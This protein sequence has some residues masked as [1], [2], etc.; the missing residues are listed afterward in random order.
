MYGIDYKTIDIEAASDAF[1]AELERGLEGKPSSLKM[2][3]AYVS[4]PEKLPEEGS[5]LAIDAG[6]TH[7]RLAEVF[8]EKEGMRVGEVQDMMMPGFREEISS[9]E[10]FERMAKLISAYGCEEV[11][12]CFSYPGRVLPDHDAEIVE[13][14]KEIFI[15][16][17]EGKILGAS[18]NEFLE[19]MGS[20]P[21]K[22]TVLNDTVAVLLGSSERL[23]E[24]HSCAMALIQGTGCNMCYVEK[25]SI[26]NTECGNYDGFPRS[27]ADIELDEGSAYAGEQLAEKMTGGRYLSMLTDMLC[28]KYGSDKKDSIHELLY[29][30][31]ARCVVSWMLGILKHCGADRA[32]PSFVCVEGSTFM[33]AQL[34]Q[35]RVYE[36]VRQYIIQSHGIDL[37]IVK[38]VDTTLTGAAAAAVSTRQR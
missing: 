24:R 7:L 34:L 33:K 28:E 36:Y 4:V 37:R 23:R 21:R 32:L 31:A 16:D 2:L 6:G 10:F 17:I 5:V 20:K 9:D 18:I 27:E 30:R 14:T 12:F 19:K 1:R 3:P 25:D 22:F 15:K 29:D 35:S 8:F 38:A 26:I 13:V 11:G